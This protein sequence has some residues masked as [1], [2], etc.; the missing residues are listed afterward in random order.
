MNVWKVDFG[1]SLVNTPRIYENQVMDGGG[2]GKVIM[3]LFYILEYITCNKTEEKGLGGDLSPSSS[4]P[5]TT[6]LAF[7]RNER[8][9]SVQIYSHLKQLIT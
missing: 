8:N 7:T 9:W 2:E 5:L 6:L 1:I 3:Y 4:F